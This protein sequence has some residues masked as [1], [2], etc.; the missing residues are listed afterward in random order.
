MEPLRIQSAS[1]IHLPMQSKYPYHPLTHMEPLRILS[2]SGI[3][4]PMRSEYPYHP[5]KNKKFIS[6]VNTKF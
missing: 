1:G 2:A 5:L 6:M 4:L 3:H